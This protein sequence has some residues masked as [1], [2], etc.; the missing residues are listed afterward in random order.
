MNRESASLPV[1]LIAGKEIAPATTGAAIELPDR[2]RLFPS[3]AVPG[4]GLAGIAVLGGALAAAGAKLLKDR[5]AT[6]EKPDPEG[7]GGTE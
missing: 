5:D 4:L 6:S 7:D 2:I 3:F 1:K